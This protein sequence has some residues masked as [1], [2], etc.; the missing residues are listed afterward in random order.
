MRKYFVT[1]AGNVGVGKSTLTKLLAD[2]LGWQPIYEAVAENPYLADFYQE[3]GRWSFHSQIF[4][5][6]RRLRQ[7]HRVMESAGTV[8]Q[9]RSVYEDAEIFARNL[10]EQGHLSQRDWENYNE[11]YQTLTEML[12]PPHLVVYLQASVETLH[13]R[14]Q[15]RGR[16]YEQ[17]IPDGYLRRLNRL[18]DQWIENWKLS[19]VLTIDT[20]NLDYVQYD[21]DLDLITARILERLQGKEYLKLP[22]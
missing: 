2:K 11:L 19:A 3:M 1:I 20:N 21:K 8:L 4:F 6:A 12:P 16:T 18:Y 22:A 7:H 13:R 14:I 15:Q 9:D 17:S 10:Y 5:L